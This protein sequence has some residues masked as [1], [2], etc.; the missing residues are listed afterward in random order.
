[1]QARAQEKINQQDKHK[2]SD[3]AGISGIIPKSL[4]SILSKVCHADLKGDNDFVASAMVFQRGLRSDGPQAPAQNRF[5][6]YSSMFTLY[7][8]AFVSRRDRA[9][10]VHVLVDRA[11]RSARRSLMH[12]NS[13]AKPFRLDTTSST[14]ATAE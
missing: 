3:R 9:G 12:P 8:P 4:I 2:S 1:M 11:G 5:L 13:L 14:L 6:E 10:G 7:S